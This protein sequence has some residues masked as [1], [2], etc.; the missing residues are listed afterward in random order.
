M[1]AAIQKELALKVRR[2]NSHGTSGDWA[3]PYTPF[4]SGKS[5][6][7]AAAQ[8]CLAFILRFVVF[9]PLQ[10]KNKRETELR[11]L[12]MQARME[13]QGAPGA[14]G[15]GGMPPPPPPMGAA[16]GRGASP[17]LQPTFRSRN[18]VGAVFTLAATRTR[19]VTPGVVNAQPDPLPAACMHGT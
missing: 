13:R 18:P 2:N 9:A 5:G 10:E 3:V 6:F 19:S 12:A 7:L 4:H 16:A 1:R 15:A 14:A 8:E 17:E 11:Q